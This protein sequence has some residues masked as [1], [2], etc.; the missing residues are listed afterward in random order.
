VCSPEAFA[1]DAYRAYFGF[2]AHDKQLFMLMRRNAGTIN[3][4]FAEGAFGVT[5]DELEEDLRDAIARGAVPPG[6]D[7]EYLAAAMVGTALEVGVRM[8][9]RDPPDVD[10]ATRFASGLFLGAFALL[11]N[12]EV[13]AEE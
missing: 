11:K 9:E 3:A 6:G 13:C 2:L 12:G 1:T 4:L 5:V 7:V 8:V 10:G